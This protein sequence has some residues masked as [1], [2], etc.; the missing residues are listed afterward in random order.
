MRRSAERLPL[1]HD[2]AVAAPHR[3]IDWRRMDMPLT[4]H[5]L[6]EADYFLRLMYEEARERVRPTDEFRFLLSGLLAAA[7]SVCDVASIESSEFR[8]FRQRRWKQSVSATD[9]G[10]VR[11]MQQQRDDELHESG[12]SV[13]AQ[14]R[15][16]HAS[17]GG[18]PSDQYA[19]TP[20]AAVIADAHERGVEIDLEDVYPG[21]VRVEWTFRGLGE[22]RPVLSVCTRYLELLRQLIDDFKNAFP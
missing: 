1:A 11:F 21:R 17:F 6:R 12:A 10:I 13:D 3:A 16:L 19:R 4:D 20:I 14:R 22:P 8:A 15:I 2:R 7:D 5:K 9:W 18:L